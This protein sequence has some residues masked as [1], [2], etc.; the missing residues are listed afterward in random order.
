VAWTRFVGSGNFESGA[1]TAFDVSGNA[2]LV[3]QTGGNVAGITEPGGTSVFLARYDPSGTRT[4]LTQ[5]GSS[6][7]DA[8]TGVAVDLAG[9]IY[10]TGDTY[11][12]LG[13]APNA[14][15]GLN[16]AYVMKLDSLGNVLWTRLLGA[17]GEEYS[18]GIGLDRQG[19]IWIG[20]YSDSRLGGRT[21]TNQFYDSFVAE[22]DSDGLLL[23][24]AFIPEG[25]ALVSSLAIAPD[26]G[27]YVTG[28]TTNGGTLQNGDYDIFV[29][30]VSSVPEPSMAALVGSGMIAFVLKR[31]RY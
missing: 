17:K 21:P 31:R 25:N 13:G 29:A 22:Y 10:L 4:L 14:G 6:G 8:V 30:K 20:G 19:H 3:G 28:I 7:V 1:A 18:N 24:T 2:Y 11:G 27:V 26:S 16:D 23:G 12:N 15:G 9:N 5:Y